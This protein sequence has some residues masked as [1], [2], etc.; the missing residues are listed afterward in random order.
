[1]KILLILSLFLSSAFTWAYPNFIGHSYTSCQNCHF[2]PFGGGQLNDYGRAVSATAIS[3]GALYPK[4]WDEEKVAY[5]SGF[6][7]RK[8]KQDWIRTQL[9]Y[10][11]FK[12]VTSP[13]GESEEE[14]YIT[15]Q[16]DAR[17]ALKFGE[18]DKFLF[19]GDYGYVPEMQSPPPGT[20]KEEYRSRNLYLGYRP[21]QKFGI[22][23]GLMDKVYGIRVVE[24]I[25]FSRINP[26]IT[27]NDQTYGVATHFIKDDWEGGVHGFIGNFN[28]DIEHRQKGGSTMIEKTIFN[29]HRV[30]GSFLTSK[31]D[32]LTI[33]SYSGHGRF[34]FKEGSALLAEVGQ[35]ERT[36]HSQVPATTSR[37]ALF[38][39]YT[40]PIRGLY[41]LANIEYQRNDINQDDYLI[42][43]APGIQWFPIQRV[44]L[45]ADI[46]NTRNFLSNDSRRDSWMY[47]LQ[48]HIW[49]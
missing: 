29:L 18:K 11:R 28:Q 16:L 46:Y 17:L 19:V 23:A 27:Q 30:G 12:I 6:L 1:M 37:F 10:R 22:Y 33:T 36:S 2:N 13:G 3:S 42:R 24:H 4:S 7:F 26:Q 43:W 49:L 44:E 38:Q 40:R 39:T 25:A 48:T 15:M 32:F 41:L 47:L 14:R 9:N 5:T 45:R 34:N 31:S 21:N 20:D 8:P 35:T